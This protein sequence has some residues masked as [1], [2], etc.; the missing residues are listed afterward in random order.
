[1]ATS[2]PFSEPVMWT[3]ERF[4]RLLELETSHISNHVRWEIL[5]QMPG[6]PLASREGV[7][8]MRV[9][10]RRAINAGSIWPPPPG[11]LGAQSEYG[12][13]AAAAHIQQV[14]DWTPERVALVKA[15]IPGHA[16]APTIEKINALPGRIL[17]EG[18][19]K[20][21]YYKR[22]QTERVAVFKDQGSQSPREFSTDGLQNE[23]SQEN[24]VPVTINEVLVWIDNQRLS[25]AG[26]RT[27]RDALD[28]AN[29]ERARW[30]IPPFRLVRKA[31]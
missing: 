2:N 13:I 25:K 19:I 27:V 7:A 4:L 1:M 23:W 16:W 20:N 5:N 11:W 22:N 9:R 31:A 3:P 30:F 10:M 15:H 17:S 18:A 14:P 8:T 26:L 24:H 12:D 6:T 28:L 21:R 29:Q